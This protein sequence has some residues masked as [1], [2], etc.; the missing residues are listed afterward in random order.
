LTV[1]QKTVGSKND[2]IEI[3]RYGQRDVKFSAYG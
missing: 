3:K 1:Q 2:K